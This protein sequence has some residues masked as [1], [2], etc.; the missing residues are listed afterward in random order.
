MS[1]IGCVDF[2]KHLAAKV[3]GDGQKVQCVATAKAAVLTHI[4]QLHLWR[5]WKTIHGAVKHRVTLYF[6]RVDVFLASHTVTR[7][8]LDRLVTDT[9]VGR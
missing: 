6:V 3:A 1:V 4:W 8:G 5:E 2:A 9:F 7:L